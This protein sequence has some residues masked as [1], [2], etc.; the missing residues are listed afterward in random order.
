MLSAGGAMKFGFLNEAQISE[1]SN[2]IL[3]EL[4]D[5]WHRYVL[6]KTDN[7]IDIRLVTHF[8]MPGSWVTVDETEGLFQ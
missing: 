5:K 3:D 4:I 6:E 7:R 2:G 8:R 1:A